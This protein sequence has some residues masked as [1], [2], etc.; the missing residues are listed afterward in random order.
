MSPE[1]AVALDALRRERIAE[2]T[3]LSRHAP[4]VAA[5]IDDVLRVARKA[6]R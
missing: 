4:K 3:N 5:A 2:G 6:T 1:L